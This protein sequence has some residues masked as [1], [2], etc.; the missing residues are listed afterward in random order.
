MSDCLPASG[1]RGVSQ[2][3]TPQIRTLN[4]E[5]VQPHRSYVLISREQI[6]RNYRA[7]CEAAGPAMKVI[8]VVKAN[9]YG[10]GAAEIARVLEAQGAEWLAV[11]CVEEGVTLRRAGIGER[12][13]RHTRILVMTG[14]LR[15]EWDA[16][17]E[18]DLTPSLDSLESVAQLDRLARQSERKV[19]Y[20]LNIDSGMTRLGLREEPEQILAAARSATH[21]RLEGLMTH[22]ASPADYTSPQT[23]QQTAYFENIFKG[24][25]RAGIHVPYIHMSSTNAIAYARNPG[26]PT[27]VRPGHAIYGYISPARGEAP[28][29]ILEVK[30][31]LA[32]KAKILAVKEIGKGTPIGYGGTFKA[33]SAMRIAIIAAGYADGLPHRLSNR[34]KIIAGGRLV[35]ILGTVCMDLTTIDISHS[36][37][38]AP[39]DE[40][41]LIGEENGVSLNAQQMARAAGTI[42]YAILCGIGARVVR[43]Y[44]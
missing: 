37:T 31:A 27:L 28:Q 23:E 3:R 44:V 38:L 8:G 26:F 12:G 19:A 30:P 39:G 41:T 25:E 42:S 17:E 5:E 9:A 29:P 20:H 21:A 22:F 2:I 43:V 40:V 32:W 10:H 36:S 14:F 34:G 24:F 35:P 33:P 18:Y 1:E 16:V 6:A 13:A 7:V 11:S 15:Y 4:N